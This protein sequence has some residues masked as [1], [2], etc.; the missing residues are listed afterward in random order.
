M[1]RIAVANI[2]KLVSGDIGAPLLDADTILVR[3]NVIVTIGRHL[4]VS[5]VEKVIDAKGMTVTP[6]LIDSHLHPVFDD[7]TPRQRSIGFMESEVQGGVTTAISAGEVHLAGRP[8]DAPGV[9][10]LAILAAK[11]SRNF[12]PGGMKLHGGAVILEPGLMEE[13]FAEMA[14]EGVWLVGEVGLGA[15]RAPEEAA[16][17]LKWAKRYG[18]ISKMHTGGTSIPGS[19]V[20]TAEM[21]FQ[22]K[23][24]VAAHINGGPTA[25]PLAE[26]ERLVRESD[27]ALE[28]CH[29]GNPKVLFEAVKIIIRENAQERVLIGNDAPSGTGIIPL[30]I[31]RTIAQVASLNGIRAPQVIAMATGNT[32]NI[33]KLNCGAIEPGR[34]A[35]LVIMDAPMGSVGEDALS[36]IEAGDTPA[37]AMVIIDGQVVV[38]KSR[39]TPPAK[40]G[41]VV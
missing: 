24:D 11:C 35:D 9:K 18:M 25:M 5:Q 33:Y 26:V 30:G 32:A 14:Q 6:G 36:A 37:I 23:P 16:T 29:C 20:V 34:E 19:S 7:Y 27:I 3:D 15:V 31:L 28:L 41:V 10:A 17:M 38:Q 39:N 8:R 4:D 22:A 1:A 13:D 2:G 40:R 21:V 12:R